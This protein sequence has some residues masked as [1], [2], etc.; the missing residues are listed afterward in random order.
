MSD[1]SKRMREAADTLE[2]WSARQGYGS[3]IDIEWSAK[4]LR[5]EAEHLAAEVAEAEKLARDLYSTLTDAE[6]PW[7]EAADWLRS[8]VLRQAERLLE[9]GWITSND[10]RN[11]TARDVGSID[12]DEWKRDVS[13]LTEFERAANCLHARWY[14]RTGGKHCPDCGTSADDE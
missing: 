7:D 8:S 11:E 13:M 2:E 14:S 4:E 3:P 5:T 10:W 9:Q 1:L 6:R 12:H